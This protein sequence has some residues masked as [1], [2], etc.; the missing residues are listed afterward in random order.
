M[1][2]PNPQQAIR[3]IRE[4]VVESSAGVLFGFGVLMFAFA[5]V[6]NALLEAPLG[7]AHYLVFGLSVAAFAM[8][9]RMSVEWQAMLLLTLFGGAATV[10]MTTYGLAGQSVVL[11]LGM[12]FLAT[13]IFGPNAGAMAGGISVLMLMT[14]MA[15]LHFDWLRFDPEVA[16]YI[17]HPLAWLSATA[18]LLAL[19]LVIRSQTAQ[20]TARMVSLWHDQEQRAHA[21]RDANDKLRSEVAER[22]RVESSLREREQSYRDLFSLSPDAVFVVHGGV[23]TD[24]NSA[25]L[26]LLRVG[27]P[28][29]AIG[30]LFSAWVG[31][32]EPDAD[33][34]T[35][36]IDIGLLPGPPS[37]TATDTGP[38]GRE[39][40]LR[41]ADGREATAELRVA[42][43]RI[44]GQPAILATLRD[45]TDRKKA[46]ARVMRLAQHDALTDLPN[47]ALLEAR[48]TL[49][50]REASRRHRRVAVMFIDLDRFKTINDTLGHATGDQLL[51]EVGRRLTSVCRPRDLLARLGGDEFVLLLTDIEQIDDV[52]AVAERV[53][54]ALREPVRLERYELTATP[55]I[56]ISTFP[57]DG[58]DGATLLK[59][60]DA[61]MYHSKSAGRNTYRYFLPQMN[62]AAL[63]RIALEQKLRNALKDDSFELHYQMQ[64]DREGRFVGM[65]ALLRWTL[66][67][68]GPIAPDRFIPIAEEIG[69]IV[70][71]GEWV[72]DRACRQA[73]L[74]LDAGM[75]AF[76]ISVNLSPA[77]LRNHDFLARVEQI[78]RSHRVPPSVIE[79]E[80]TESA[81]MENPQEAIQVLAGLKRLGLMLAIDDF[82][83]GYSSLS[84]LKLFPIDHLKID[85][86][87]VR[88]LVDDPNDRAIAQATIAL[89]HSLGLRVIAEGVETE[90]QAGMLAA[91]GCDE[92]QGYLYGRPM[93]IE[94][95]EA[96][97]RRDQRQ[98]LA[99]G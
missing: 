43:V 4:D 74:W 16:G 29:K 11:L 31:E 15:A 26:V 99:A 93:P 65:E 32:R 14:T 50:L 1:A 46:E 94:R 22:T 66:P 67:D 9:R 91:F 84:Y 56:G 25:A 88:D 44:D 47:R 34:E 69:L 64:V 37:F 80:I 53:L 28:E 68:Q 38:R 96:L 82:G 12:I 27:Q 73:R 92:M 89:A 10:A 7:F 85:R 2:Q 24:L 23:I 55:S 83:T 95:L 57:D 51:I 70:P 54:G 40:R 19:T 33:A 75:P 81:A 8:R 13:T 58:E 97:V 39:V 3:Q 87:F 77:Q 78:V 61:A 79:L 30:T 41:P 45:I 20:L 5:V 76:R 90:E 71:L 98:A 42:R 72:L 6:R 48:L 49:A 63:D 18:T 21:L 52:T 35:T 60:A 86:S 62:K 17:S 59:H 36:V